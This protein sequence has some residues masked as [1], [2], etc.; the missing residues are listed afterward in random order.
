MTSL[1]D[2]GRHTNAEGSPQEA[3]SGGSMYY[4][5]PAH[6]RTSP[7]SFGSPLVHS[8]SDD[9]D[10]EVVIRRVELQFTD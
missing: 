9:C 2:A 7:V 6:Q 8:L 10:I 5:G 4:N 1:D 3:F